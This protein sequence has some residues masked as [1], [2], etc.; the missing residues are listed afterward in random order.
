MSQPSIT[1]TLRARINPGTD[2]P[3]RPILTSLNG[4]NS[5]LISLPRPVSE[6]SSKKKAKKY[7][8]IVSDPWLVGEAIV[9]ARW[10]VT[11]PLPHSSAYSSGDAV[12]KLVDEI[13]AAASYSSS[14]SSTPVSSSSDSNPSSE[15][16]DSKT[17]AGR[18]GNGIDA[19]FISF[20]LTDHLHEETLRTF[21]PSTPVFVAPGKSSSI[22][23]SWNY[24]QKVTDIRDFDPS[25]P[26]HLK[27]WKSSLHPETGSGLPDWINFFRC[28]GH[29]YLGFATVAVWSSASSLSSSSLSSSPPASTSTGDPEPR[30]RPVGREE[31]GEKH[32]AII[33]SPHGI[34]TDQPTIRALLGPNLTPKIR[35][36]AILHAL[37]E[38]FAFGAQ[39]TLGVKG[40]LALERLARPRYW[41]KSHDAMMQYW[42]VISWLANTRDVGRCLEDGLMEET[43]EPVKGGEDGADGTERGKG[44]RPNLVEVPNGDCFVLE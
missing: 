17:A 19:I 18:N 1:K 13:E 32:E 34:K 36:L 29:N 27:S 31:T 2:T 21:D 4:D 9:I 41:V 35:V 16:T 10:A 22:I 20:H 6:R 23:R 7:F 44:R 5:W 40:G 28:V 30:S 42:G 43:E 25:Q 14:P 11:T 26:R 33:Y 39:Q 24:F 38:N 37:K 3:L 8:H 15:D 12:E